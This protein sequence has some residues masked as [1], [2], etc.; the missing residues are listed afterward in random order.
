MCIIVIVIACYLG[1]ALLIRKKNTKV[2]FIVLKK[3]Y[4]EKL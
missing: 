2:E 1:L 4:L 3:K